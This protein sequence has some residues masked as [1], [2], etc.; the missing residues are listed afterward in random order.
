MTLGYTDGKTKL[1]I[2][3][4]SFCILGICILTLY[5]LR[6]VMQGPEIN[7]DCGECTGMISTENVYTLAG[8]TSNISE[9][10]LGNKKIYVNSQ[11]QFKE[12][13]LLYPGQNLISLN[14]K[15]RFGKEVKKDISVYYNNNQTN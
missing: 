6:K 2:M 5:E 12:T 14:A 11:G 13:V 9:I 10:F 3:C 8:I 15:D 1:K 4:F 7:I